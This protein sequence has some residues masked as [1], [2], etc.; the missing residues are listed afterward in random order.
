MEMKKSGGGITSKNNVSN[1]TRT[2]SGSKGI[3]PGWVGQRGEKVGDHAELRDS[4]GYRGE[5]KFT[6]NSFQPVKFGNE[7]ALNVGKGG[8]GT[9]REVMR[10][11]T[12]GVQGSTVA[13]NP[14]QR[15]ELFPGWPSKP[16][17]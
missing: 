1:T 5:K 15:N 17:P 2:G 6:G 12:Q 10:C 8:P 4:V 7:V 14:P 16:R 3:R 13:G 11:G 9:G